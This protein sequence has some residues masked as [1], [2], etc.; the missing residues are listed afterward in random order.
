MRGP[1]SE[2]KT[3]DAAMPNMSDDK[4]RK[5]VA[6]QRKALNEKKRTEKAAKRQEKA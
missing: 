2:A 5:I 1:E 4:R 6:K 3:E